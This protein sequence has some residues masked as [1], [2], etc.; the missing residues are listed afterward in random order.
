MI[1]LLLLFAEIAVLIK[2]G[3]TIGAG[4]VFLEILGTAAF[5]WILV[6]V[7]GRTFARTDRLVTLFASPARYLRRSE[8]SL[9]LAGALLIVPGI[10]SDLLGL[11]LAVRFLTTR[12]RPAGAGQTSTDPDVIDVEYRVH[13]DGSSE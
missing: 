4:P 11:A 13:E 12:R 3:Q 9:F 10:L 1:V 7:A 6:R 8:W 2:L 5:G